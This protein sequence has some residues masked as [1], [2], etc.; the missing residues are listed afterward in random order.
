MLKSKDALQIFTSQ[1]ISEIAN[2][3]YSLL[4]RVVNEF[5]QPRF[6]PIKIADI[7]D[8]T[9]SKVSIDYKNE[10]FYK[11]VIAN[12]IFLKKHSPTK[13]TMI[14]ELRIGS[15]KADCVIL[16]GYSTC[17][18]IKTEFDNLKRLPEQLNNYCNIFDRVYVVSAEKHVE[19]ILKC[20]P[21]NVGVILLTKRG[22]LKEVR[23]AI[24]LE[25]SVDPDLMI[26]SL[27][28]D[29]YVYIA[30]K[31]SK[32]D[33]NVSNMNIYEHCLKIFKT[34]D[35]SS[36]RILFRESLKKYRSV[37]LELLNKVPQSLANSVISCRLKLT[38]QENL[39]NILSEYIERDDKCIFH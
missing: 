33:V 30:E 27:R 9:L 21:E 2:G 35:S 29:E 16:N 19:K 17:Y 32:V 26:Q 28:R 14:N 3:D 36:L 5:I 13:A 34:E 23:K 10:Y 31:I 37:N 1:A 20:I 7:F 25:S 11:N 4:Y 12:N 24:T 39:A 18:E 8:L 22:T 6:M 38:E 15:S